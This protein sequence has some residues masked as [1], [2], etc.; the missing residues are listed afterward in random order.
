MNG[1]ELLGD[2]QTLLDLGFALP[3]AAVDLL[4]EDAR[5]SGLPWRCGSML[6]GLT[7]KALAD[8]ETRCEAWCREVVP[9][10]HL[11]QGPIKA[12]GEAQYHLLNVCLHGCEKCRFMAHCSTRINGHEAEWSERRFTCLNPDCKHIDGWRMY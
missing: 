10:Q 6:E 3:E 8:W 4:L 5:N 1:G 12:S 9:E 2:A 11:A 7:P